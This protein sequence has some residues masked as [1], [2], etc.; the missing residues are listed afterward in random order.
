MCDLLVDKVC[1]ISWLVKMC[2]LLVGK[3]VRSLG[4]KVC[5]ISWLIKYV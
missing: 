3:Y 5:V 1:V 2:D 4:C